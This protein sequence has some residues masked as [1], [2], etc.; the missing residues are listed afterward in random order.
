MFVVFEQI[1]S[2][3][4][5]FRT[6]LLKKLFHLEIFTLLKIR[7]TSKRF[8]VRLAFFKVFDRF[9]VLVLFGRF[10]YFQAIFK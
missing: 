6:S 1:L 8:S 5:R 9:S 3:L 2:D 7:I 10:G 4:K